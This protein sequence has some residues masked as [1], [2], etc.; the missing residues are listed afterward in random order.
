MSPGRLRRTATG[1]QVFNYAALGGR[2]ELAL[3]YAFG[4]RVRAR[5]LGDG[6]GERLHEAFRE[7]ERRRRR[8]CLPT[9]IGLD[10]GGAIGYFGLGYTYRFNTPFGSTPFVTLE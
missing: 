10:E 8:A 7:P 3:S 6:R 5:H 9:Q 1:S 4:S 2:A